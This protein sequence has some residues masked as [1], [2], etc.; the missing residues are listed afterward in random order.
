V[1]IESVADE[2]AADADRGA[3]E[4]M[5]RDLMECV[6]TEHERTMLALYYYEELTIA[7]VAAVLTVSPSA[8]ARTIKG[9]LAKLKSAIANRER[10]EP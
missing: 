9:A 6:L 10:G 8:A 3:E 2:S 4:A 1:E 7:E 5:I